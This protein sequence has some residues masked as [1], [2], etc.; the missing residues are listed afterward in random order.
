MDAVGGDLAALAEEHETIS[1]VPVLNHIQH[2]VDLA[3]ECLLTQIPA[4]EACF[5]R[6]AEFTQ[7]LVGRVHTLGYGKPEQD[8]FRSD[9]RRVRKGCVRTVRYRW[10]QYQ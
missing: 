10:R 8:R 9:E 1:A 3:A 6:A 7:R 4:S 5:D 2:F